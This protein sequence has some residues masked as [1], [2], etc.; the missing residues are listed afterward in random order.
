MNQFNLLVQRTQYRIGIIRKHIH[1]LRGSGIAFI[2]YLLSPLSWWNDLLLNIPLAYVFALGIS[3][4][5]RKLFLMAFIGGYWA[6]NILGLIMLHHG[7]ASTI[8]TADK[9][10]S[11]H[12]LAF[13]VLFS[14]AY[15]G[16]I[17]L[18]VKI[19]SL[20]FP[21]SIQSFMK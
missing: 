5:F 1:R 2:G 12:A 18:L 8:S 19:G 14:L 17:V 6:T 21:N 15:T 11:R 16:L 7:V 9:K 4:F 10:Y 13:D 20:Q 3:F